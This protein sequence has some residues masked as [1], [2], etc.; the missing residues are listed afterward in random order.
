MSRPPSSSAPASTPPRRPSPASA[1]RRSTASSR[2]RCSSTSSS[3]RPSCSPSSSPTRRRPRCS[4]RPRP[5]GKEIAARLAVKTE[6]GL[7]TDAVDVQAGRT[8]ASRRPSRSSPAPTPCRPRS[9]RARPIVT[10]K[11]NSATPEEAAGAAADE[12]ARL[13]PVRRRQGREDHRVQAE[14]GHRP[15]RADRGRDRRLRRPRHRP[16]TSPRSRPSPT[17]SAPP[18]VPRRAAV[19]AGWYPHTSQVGQTGKQV[20]PQLYVACGISGAIQHRAGMQTSKTIV[21][22]NKDNEAPIFELVDFGVVGDLFT[23]LPAGHR[24]DQGR[25]GLTAAVRQPHGCRHVERPRTGDRRRGRLVDV[26]ARRQA[27]SGRGRAGPC[28][29]VQLSRRSRLRA[30][31][32]R[33]VPRVHHGPR[34]ASDGSRTGRDARTGSPLEHGRP[35]IR[36]APRAGRPSSVASV[37]CDAQAPASRARSRADHARQ[38]RASRDSAGTRHTS[39]G[40]TGS[41]GTRSDRAGGRRS[42]R[43]PGRRGPGRPGAHAQ[44]RGAVLLVRCRHLSRHPWGRFTGTVP[45]LEEPTAGVATPGAAAGAPRQRWLGAVGGAA[46]L[47][48]PVLTAYLDHA[49]TTPMLPAALAAMTE[50]LAVV[51]NPS[52]LHRT[53]RAAPARRR[54]VTRE[55]RPL[56]RRAALRGA[57]S[58]PVAPSPTTSRSRAPT[59]PAAT[60]D[61]R[62]VRLLVGA[63][64]HH[65]VLDCVDFLVAHEGAKVTWLECTPDGCRGARDGAGRHR[66]RP[67]LRRPGRR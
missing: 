25:Q 32:V 3:P 40:S 38:P 53:G 11:P 58:P 42:S 7:I 24:G 51:G 64:E 28:R 37:L 35:T 18:S 17:R 9:P 66:V 63:I 55:D 29:R 12:V 56:P 30:Y 14:A 5:E 13:H 33:P 20:S 43:R 65:A 41:A 15:P 27:A 23:V 61:P 6:S 49:A 44:A 1:P 8:V 2:P 48:S 39:I 52:S 60:L 54:G 10:V 50:Q 19:D 16:A 62:R 59:G 34:S 21:A 4:C 31:A 36:A 47:E 45:R 26:C 22:V 57:S 46:R 67:G